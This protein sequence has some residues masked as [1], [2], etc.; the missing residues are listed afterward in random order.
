MVALAVPAA[1]TTA[2]AAQAAPAPAA[3]A[4]PYRR[5][6]KPK[7]DAADIYRKKYAPRVTAKLMEQGKEDEAAKFEAWTQSQAGTAYGKSWMEAAMRVGQGDAVGAMPLLEDLYN[8]QM[9]D[10]QYAKLVPGEGGKYTVEV[11][12]EKSNKK[13]GQHTGDVQEI[14]QLG[15]AM[16]SPEARY[17][18]EVATAARATAKREG[19]EKEDRDHLRALELEAAKASKPPTPMEIERLIAKRD[20]L[21]AENPKH[22]D[23]P[24]YERLI[25]NKGTHAPAP[26]TTLVVGSTPVPTAGGGYGL[27]NAPKGGGPARLV[28]LEG[29]TNPVSEAQAYVSNYVM[30]VPIGGT[31]PI[32]HTLDGQPAT[33]AERDEYAKAQILLKKQPGLAR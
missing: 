25:N 5:V 10:G 6:D 19:L 32:L 27:V 20:A 17:A 2:P 7:L 16:L 3:E 14:A 33:G 12:D 8:K 1:G 30:K 21:R 23:L 13:V 15:V 11:Y 29:A 26:A 28:P 31:S 18:Q 22:P 24:T 9:P 4:D